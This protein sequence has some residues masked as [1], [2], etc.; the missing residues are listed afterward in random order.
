[1][2][3]KRQHLHKSQTAIEFLTTYGWA[4]LIIGIFISIIII[5][6]GTQTAQSYLPYSCTITPDIYCNEALLVSNS[7]GSEFIVVFTTYLGQDMN[8]SANSLIVSIGTSPTKYYGLCKPVLAGRGAVVTCNATMS[9][10]TLGIGQQADVNFAVSYKIC[11]NSA[12]CSS[13]NHNSQYNT[14][15]Y[16]VLGVSP[17]QGGLYSLKLE[18]SPTTG[19]I[20]F[21]GKRYPNNAVVYGIPNL[22]YTIYG[23]PPNG[24]TFSSWS[25]TGG[26]SVSSASLQSTKVRLVSS[27]GTLTASFLIAN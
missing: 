2:Q 17:F 25:T 1:M 18:T 9:G 16:S 5:V 23:V 3:V 4:L 14:S 27:S 19:N 26:V 10:Y 20:V 11:Q 22:Y 15:G 21:Q 6:V 24:Y 13:G 12:V 8:F 7:I